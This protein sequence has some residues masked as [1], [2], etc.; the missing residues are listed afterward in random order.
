MCDT[1]L[2]ASGTKQSPDFCLKGQKQQTELN[3]ISRH[4]KAHVYHD[5]ERDY[6]KTMMYQIQM[7]I[8]T[9]IVWFPRWRIFLI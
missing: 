8:H 1:R 2:A 5:T 6:L 7:I 3:C 4:L 9:R